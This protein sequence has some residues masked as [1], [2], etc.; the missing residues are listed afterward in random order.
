MNAFPGKSCWRFPDTW[1]CRL[2]DLVIKID[3]IGIADA[4]DLICD[5]IR[6][7]AFQTTPESQRQIQQRWEEARQKMEEIAKGGAPFL[8]PMR[9]F[10]WSR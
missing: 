8:E 1:D 9:S 4:V 3:K 5:T 2:Y 7:P 6:R 10:P